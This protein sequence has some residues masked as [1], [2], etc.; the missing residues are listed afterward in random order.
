MR[1]NNSGIELVVVAIVCIMLFTGMLSI[2]ASP[3]C[4]MSECNDRP[5]TDSCYCH[6]HESYSAVSH[7]T[8]Y[9]KA[10]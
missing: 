5:Q 3:H 2:G 10:D 8:I 6:T 9:S 4:I 7:N 1:K